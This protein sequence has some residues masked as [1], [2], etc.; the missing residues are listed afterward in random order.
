MAVVTYE[1]LGATL[2]C[3]ARR[4]RQ[5]HSQGTSELHLPDL[6]DPGYPG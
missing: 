6:S 1:V 4:Q 2:G 5:R 3:A